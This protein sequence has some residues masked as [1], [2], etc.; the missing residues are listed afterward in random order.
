MLKPIEILN[1]KT[2]LQDAIGVAVSEERM[3]DAHRMEGQI[4][5]LDEMLQDSLKEEAELAANASAITPVFAPKNMGQRFLGARNQF[6][7]LEEGNSITIP[8]NADTA[9]TATAPS[10]VSIPDP[11]IEETTVPG[12][13]ESPF[14][15]FADT[16]AKGTCEGDVK[17]MRRKN[18]GINVKPWKSG[19]TKAVSELTWEKK[20]ASVELLATYIPVEIPSLSRYGELES[21]INNELRIGLAE[22]KDERCLQGDDTE[23]MVGVLNTAGIQTYTA[24]TGEHPV[25]SIRRMVTL[26][27]MNSRLYPTHIV[28]AP[29]VKE[30]IDLLKDDNGAY[31]TLM[32]NGRIWNLPVIEDVNMVTA[33]TE[34]VD[35]KEVTTLHFGMMV[36]FGQAAT[37]FSCDTQTLRVGTV[38]DQF[39]KNQLSLLLEESNALKITY[40]DAFVYCADAITAQVVS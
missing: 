24:K 22:K 39:V 26:A 35:S 29:Q 27:I 8:L 15:T 32:T 3:E 20:T 4:T 40:P 10:P 31:L 16:L 18:H 5:I 11:T 28:C 6:K 23:G 2:M 21:T 12:W 14:Y 9:A 37:L 19:E 30:A 36:Y 17:Y 25:D 34:T 1:K 13:G 33:T 7:P 38:N